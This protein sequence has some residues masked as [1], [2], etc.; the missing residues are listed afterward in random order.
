MKLNDQYLQKQL[1]LLKKRFKAGVLANKK[2]GRRNKQKI[3]VSERGSMS[4]E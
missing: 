1:N 4:A 2:K 3:L